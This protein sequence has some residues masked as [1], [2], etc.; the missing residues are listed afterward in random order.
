MAR[1]AALGVVRARPGAL[2]N[3]HGPPPQALLRLRLTVLLRRGAEQPGQ[4]AGRVRPRSRVGGLPAPPRDAR[5][6]RPARVVP[7]ERGGR[8][9]GTCRAS[10]RGSGSPT[11]RRPR[12]CRTPAAPWPSPSWRATRAGSTTSGAH[13]FDAYW[14]RG[15]GI[16]GDD[17]LRR[18]GREIGL[19]P[20]AAVA[21]ASDPRLLARVDGARRRAARGRRHRHPHLRLR[22]G[23]AGG[24]LPAVRGARRRSPAGRRPAA[25]AGIRPRH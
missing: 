16:E 5:G 4:A 6:R 9:S 1:R 21:A 14:R 2:T 13:A 20:D 12:T 10:P 25:L 11:S 19:E 8:C 15:L 18:M 3:D 24:G 17:D 23:G 22:R 7:A